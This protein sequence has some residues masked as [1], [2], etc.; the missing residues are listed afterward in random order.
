MA[1]GKK[2]GGVFGSF[3][4]AEGL[5]RDLDKL[6]RWA[7]TICM[8]LNIGKVLDSAAGVG[9]SWM[10]RQENERLER[11]VVNYQSVSKGGQ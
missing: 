3:E 8:K 1:D 2:L 4:G 11:K 6:Q 10:Y 7:I 5:Q 9:Q